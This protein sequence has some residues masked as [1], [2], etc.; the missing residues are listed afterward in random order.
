MKIGEK[1]SQ[2]EQVNEKL[3]V[4]LFFEKNCNVNLNMSAKVPSGMSDWV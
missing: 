1:S 3:K 2:D 4:L